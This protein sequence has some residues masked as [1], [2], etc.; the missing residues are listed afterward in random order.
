[1][2]F[3]KTLN[4]LLA[5]TINSQ[6]LAYLTL[7]ISLLFTYSNLN[8]QRNLG[9]IEL[10]NVTI[11]NADDGN[12]LGTLDI[13]DLTT[14]PSFPTTGNPTTSPSIDLNVT[15]VTLESYSFNDNGAAIPEVYNVWYE[16]SIDF[17]EITVEDVVEFSFY[18]CG[19]GIMSGTTSISESWT[20]TIVDGILLCYG[21]DA[22]A[23]ITTDIDISGTLCDLVVISF[24]P[25]TVS[26]N[27]CLSPGGGPTQQIV[28]DSSG[29]GNQSANASY[30]SKDCYDYHARYPV[31]AEI[32]DASVLLGST[33]ETIP[34]VGDSFEEDFY[35]PTCQP[36]RLGANNLYDV[37][38]ML[39]NFTSSS[40]EVDVYLRTDNNNATLWY[41]NIDISFNDLDLQNSV[42]TPAGDINFLGFDI[43]NNNASV[44]FGIQ[45]VLPSEEQVFIGKLRFNYLQSPDSDPTTTEIIAS[46]SFTVENTTTMNY[47]E[48]GISKIATIDSY[49]T[50][51][52]LYEHTSILDESPDDTIEL[53]LGKIGDDET[54]NSILHLSP[55]PAK[56]NL[57][58][59]I[60][61]R[62]E[63]ADLVIFNLSGKKVYEEKIYNNQ[64]NLN[65]SEFQNG[66][67]IV[68]IQTE[69][70]YYKSKILVHA[71]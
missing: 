8:A 30:S 11:L 26:S 24:V 49:D 61:V 37:N 43:D 68:S 1:M 70:K 25:G 58:I 40:I 10:N 15:H 65:V 27:G 66:L 45:N 17:A 64:I 9:T 23:V 62:I 59:D 60:P 42:F 47:L 22:S 3:F 7:A 20:T 71:D 29:L 16:F 12:D 44:K 32:R 33:E 39:S 67:Y 63:I 48:G 34:F 52:M 21:A 46:S 36:D 54:Y 53:E 50:E 51:D 35:V 38:L 69:T 14:I 13:G 4:G 28:I 6:F 18:V 55:N 2:N 19:G 31:S 41:G 57:H 5:K 56:N